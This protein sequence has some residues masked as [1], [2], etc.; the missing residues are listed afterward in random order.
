MTSTFLR[1][2]DRP[3]AGGAVAQEGILS[4]SPLE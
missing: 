2:I 3:A 4:T 1:E